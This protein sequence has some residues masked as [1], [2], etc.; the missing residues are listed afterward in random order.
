MLPFYP[1]DILFQCFTM[2]QSVSSCFRVFQF[3]I[4]SIFI[5]DFVFLPLYTAKKTLSSFACLVKDFQGIKGISNL[6]QCLLKNILR[7]FC[8]NFLTYQTYTLT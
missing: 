1:L 8:L 6:R 7:V 2:C 4:A 3:F 5:E